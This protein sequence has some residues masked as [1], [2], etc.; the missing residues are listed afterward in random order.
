MPSSMGVEIDVLVAQAAVGQGHQQP[1]AQAD[2]GDG[3]GR[4]TLELHDGVAGEACLR[5]AEGRA[6]LALAI[7]AGLGADGV[8]GRAA[9]RVAGLR[10]LAEIAGRWAV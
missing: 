5:L 4:T 2:L 3:L 10:A 1:V 7:V 8:G 6:F 9:D